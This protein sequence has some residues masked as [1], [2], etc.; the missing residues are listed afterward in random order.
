MVSSSRCPS[1]IHSC[2][3]PA[4]FEPHGRHVWLH[5]MVVDSHFDCPVRESGSCNGLKCNPNLSDHDETQSGD[6]CMT[7]STVSEE[8]LPVFGSACVR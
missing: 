4:S 8:R 7:L 2:W 5:C 6:T 1:E 3:T